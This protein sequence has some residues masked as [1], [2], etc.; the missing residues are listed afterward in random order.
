MRRIESSRGRR[1]E[2]GTALA[3]L[4]I[5]LPLLL[6]TSMV[7]FE[8]AAMIRTH[9]ILN[10]AARE[11]ARFAVQPENQGNTGGLQQAVIDY[12][13]LNDVSI[14]AAQ[15]SV[16]QGGSIPGPNGILMSSSV[17]TVTRPYT[18]NILPNIPGFNISNSVT[19]VGRAGFRNFY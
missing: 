14:T 16:D 6:F 13:A 4:A 5:V 15:V 1:G 17:V 11:G 2:R 18:L 10:N 8:G 7:V 9:Q 19:L 12:A 3:E